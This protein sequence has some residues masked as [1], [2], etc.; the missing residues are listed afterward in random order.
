M[1]NTNSRAGG[2][3]SIGA[4]AR[5]TGCNIETIRYYERTGLLPLPARDSG[6]RRRYGADDAKRLAF[7]RRG[8]QLG[9][10]LADIRTL[11]GLAAGGGRCA[12]VR[13]V[14]LAHLAAVREK[15]ADLGR[16]EAVLAAAAG[17]CRGAGR[18]PDCPILD[19]LAAS[20]PARPRRL[21]LAAR[22]G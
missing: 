2:P 22:L 5:R 3:L 11:I 15:L 13:R 10:S 8:R 6:G 19:V 17:R 18:A 1:A 14:T 9:F 21:P 7:V 16:L 4:L 20:G 12:D